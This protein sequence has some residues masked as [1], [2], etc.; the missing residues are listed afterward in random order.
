MKLTV[1]ELSEIAII[2]TLYI[3]MTLIV[4]VSFGPIQFRVSE[5]LNFVVI[6]KPKY[7]IGVVLGVFI[8]NIFSSYGLD[9]I[10]GTL[11]TMLSFIICIA[12]FQVIKDKKLR[13][14]IVTLVFSALISIIAWEITIIDQAPELFWTFYLTLMLSE[15]T[16]LGL[17]S[18][19]M[20]QVEKVL[21]QKKII[22]SGSK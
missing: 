20:W 12:I 18:F 21:E 19:I 16:V 6:F 3:V 4:P 14:L 22:D 1:K 5:M 15:L 2:T 13:Y 11:H 7:A 9:V 17:G 8:S 10:F